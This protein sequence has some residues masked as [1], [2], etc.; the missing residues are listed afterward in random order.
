MS[1]TDFGIRANSVHPGFV[2][3][4]IWTPLKKVAPPWLYK[5]YRFVLRYIC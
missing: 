5:A 2:D 4:E 1:I 3:T